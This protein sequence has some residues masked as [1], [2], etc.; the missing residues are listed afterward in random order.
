MLITAKRSKLKP[1]GEFQCGSRLFWWTWRSNISAVDWHIW[2]RFD[3]PIAV[4]LLKSQAWPNR[5]LE[6]ALRRY[7]RHLVKSIWRHNSVGG[8]QIWTQFARLMQNYMPT[9]VK[10]SIWKPEVDFKYGDRLLLR[11]RSS[12]RP[13]DWLF[14]R[15]FVRKQLCTFRSVR[16]NHTR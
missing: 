8:H 11:I 10:R 4:G 2:S 7:G 1:G 5:K 6:I 9:A 14:D 16:R 12:K 3:M 15:H 13:S